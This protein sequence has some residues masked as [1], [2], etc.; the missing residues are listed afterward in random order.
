MIF[1]ASHKQTCLEFRIS[2]YKTIFWEV[3]Y[4]RDEWLESQV[5]GEC[6]SETW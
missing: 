3:K 6:F 5:I 1:T 4:G 2:N